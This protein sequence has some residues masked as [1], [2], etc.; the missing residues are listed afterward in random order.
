LGRAPRA[1]GD[2]SPELLTLVDGP[3]AE[4]VSKAAD[5]AGNAISAGTVETYKGDW[6]DFSR[7]ARQNGVDPAV[8]PVH[9]VVVAA[10]LATL[11]PSIGR[12]ALRRRIAAIACIIAASAM[13]GSQGM[14]RSGR[15]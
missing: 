8:L 5:Y 10:W 12:S 15:R 11:A 3:L 4:A 1:R 9:P 14:R 7:W 13:P 6:G 2:I